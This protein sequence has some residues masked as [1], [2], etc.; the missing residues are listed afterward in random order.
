M[1]NGEWLRRAGP[2]EISEAPLPQTEGEAD[3]WRQAAMQNREETAKVREQLSRCK[4]LLGVLD[5][6]L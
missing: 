4:G 1:K 2:F 5:E 3:F 6:L